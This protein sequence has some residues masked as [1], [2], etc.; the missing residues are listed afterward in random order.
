MTTLWIIYLVITA[1]IIVAMITLDLFWRL[2]RYR[3]RLW[4]ERM[5]QEYLHVL[6]VSQISCDESVPNFPMWHSHDGLLLMSEVMARL[7][8][9]TC[10]L[11]SA[12]LMRII[13]HYGIDRY[14]L[15]RV[16]FTT[17]YRR[18]Y[19]LSIIARLPVSADVV[20]DVERYACRKNRYVCFYT[21]LIR[22]INTPSA[23]LPLIATYPHNFSTFELSE[24]IS[25]LQRGVLQIDYKP[26]IASGNYNQRALGLAIVRR[27]GVESAEKQLLHIID[28]EINDEL[29]REAIYT[30]CA[31]RRPLSA[32]VVR[33][34]VLKMAAHDRK[35][36]LRHM[37]FEEYS[38]AS[39]RGLCA[40]VEH[41]YC[42]SLLYSYKR[43]LVC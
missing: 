21:L 30:L 1:A 25:V 9:S 24:I 39:M 35:A 18:A 15:R 38:V 6:L 28:S 3:R 36:L 4:R 40:D 34:R 13:E 32:A 42:E 23:S 26:L 11:D 29:V 16:R 41:N 17:G 7:N 31:L 43:S 19:Y 22:L 10:G 8:A 5:C 37:A 33:R 27:F 2:H 20:H 14:L 12:M